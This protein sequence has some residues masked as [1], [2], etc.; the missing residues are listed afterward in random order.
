MEAVRQEAG[1]TEGRQALLIEEEDIE[2]PGGNDTFCPRATAVGGCVSSPTQPTTAWRSK[3]NFLAFPSIALIKQPASSCSL[4]PGVRL[5]RT[6]GPSSGSGSRDALISLDL[7][8]R[9]RFLI[10]KTSL[11]QGLSSPSS[12]G[13]LGCARFCGR[14]GIKRPFSKDLE[15]E[16][17]GASCW[18]R[19]PG[20]GMLS[21]IFGC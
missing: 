12:G 6:Q 10:P 21:S 14:S 4:D 18:L 2:D 9:R 17:D 7:S 1:E 13:D 19:R 15:S 8:R 3:R 11:I 20:S 5:L 16:S